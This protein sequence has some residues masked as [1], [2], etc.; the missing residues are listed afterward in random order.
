[1]YK[2]SV[3][4]FRINTET[5]ECF[6]VIFFHNFHSDFSISLNTCPVKKKKIVFM[7]AFRLSWAIHSWN[8]SLGKSN[9]ERK[10]TSHI[11]NDSVVKVLEPSLGQFPDHSCLF[12]VNRNGPRLCLALN[13]FAMRF[14]GHV[15]DIIAHRT[16]LLK[17]R[18]AIVG[19]CIGRNDGDWR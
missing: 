13:T 18:E 4:N 3:D 7:V 8:L 12:H 15:S 10:N 17:I 9:R 14:I 11:T 1:M 2:C 19:R 6:C 5:L 16:R